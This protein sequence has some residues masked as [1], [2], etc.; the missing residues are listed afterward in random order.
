MFKPKVKLVFFVDTSGSTKL[1]H[2]KNEY[3]NL[4]QQKLE[5]FKKNDYNKFD[6][7]VKI[8][9]FAKEIKEHQHLSDL[10][11]RVNK[12]DIKENLVENFDIVYEKY[13]SETNKKNTSFFLITDYKEEELKEEAPLI[14][15]LIEKDILNL[16]FDKTETIKESLNIKI[17]I[18]PEAIFVLKRIFILVGIFLALY[19]I[20]I[21]FSSKKDIYTEEIKKEEKEFL[22]ENKTEIK[23][24]KLNITFSSKVD[25]ELSSF[26]E[27]QIV[28]EY[29]LENVIYS[30]KD[31]ITYYPKGE[32]DLVKINTDNNKSNDKYFIVVKM[33]ELV[34]KRLKEL[35][36]KNIDDIGIDITGVADGMPYTQGGRHKIQQDITVPFNIN[37][38][39]FQYIPLKKGQKI[40]N[41]IML[42]C[43]RSYHLG[44]YLANDKSLIII[45]EA[46]RNN[47]ISYAADTLKKIGGQYRATKI[48]IVFKEKRYSYIY[49]AFLVLF[50]GLFTTYIVVSIKPKINI[51]LQKINILYQTNKEN[52]SDKTGESTDTEVLTQ[53]N[54]QEAS[55]EIEITTPPSHSLLS[56][57]HKINS[58]PNTNMPNQKEIK[59]FLASSN[60]MKEDRDNI[61]KLIRNKNDKWQKLN[62]P[63]IKLEIWEDK[64][65]SMSRTRSQ[66]EYNKMIPEAE[67]FIMLFWHKVGKFTKEEFLIA[68]DAFLKTGKPLVFVYK[69]ACLE[70]ELE[71][72]AKDFEAELF[73]EGKEYFRG[74]Y[75]HFDT[76]ALKLH[77]EIERVY[78]EN[79]SKFNPQLSNN[80]ES[81]QARIIS[82]IDKDLDK[83]FE[84]L[85]DIFG[86]NNGLYNDL[87]DEYVN[88]PNGFNKTNFRK[89][90]K[91]TRR[92]KQNIQRIIYF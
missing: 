41:N 72:S 81:N 84:L 20:S 8:Y 90:T 29:L 27:Y 34:T 58:N 24:R 86:N 35:Q 4:I 17:D 43:L 76:L 85:D 46:E 15:S 49:I 74:A 73:Q 21:N 12:F 78:E 42:A 51:F 82:L 39:G 6:I 22:E 47:K 56:K 14:Y 83:A 18:K 37:K 25:K 48:A 57:T 31:S 68:K 88:M 75:D 89:T 36:S 33:T 59:I 91:I 66:D 92:E 50:S 77:K 53:T 65:E 40:N 69:K 13:K 52:L 10:D 38:E 54:P 26:C 62:R 32:Y 23:N 44:K 2:Y 16:N 63:Y 19:F 5:E 11:T 3:S 67:I 80:E 30:H 55:V 1:Y 45:Q 9:A 28:E 70:K 60:E 71:E 61:E 79:G 87:A 7:E 64:S